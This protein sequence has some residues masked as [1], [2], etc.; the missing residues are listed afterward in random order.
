MERLI[1]LVAASFVRNGIDC[2]V[3]A[4]LRPA[5]P[6]SMAS[7]ETMQSVDIRATEVILSAALP[8]HNF[9]KG[10]QGDPAP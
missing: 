1:E 2:P 9:R 10:R 4:N 5:G 8:E 6:V 7:A 3:A